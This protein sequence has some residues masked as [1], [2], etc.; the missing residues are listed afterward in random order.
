M[1]DG[2]DFN[3]WMTCRQTGMGMNECATLR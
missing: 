1:A 2:D 3:D